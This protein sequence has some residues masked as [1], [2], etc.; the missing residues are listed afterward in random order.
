MGPDL[1]KRTEEILLDLIAIPSVSPMSN[2]PLID[3]ATRC[4]DPRF[5]EFHRD[6]LLYL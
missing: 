2:Q 4:L 5:W 6:P 1:V 3:Y